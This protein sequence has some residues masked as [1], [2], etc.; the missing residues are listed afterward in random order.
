MAV[1]PADRLMHAPTLKKWTDF[2]DHRTA[3]RRRAA[4]HRVS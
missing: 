1:A 2:I 4:N 3:V